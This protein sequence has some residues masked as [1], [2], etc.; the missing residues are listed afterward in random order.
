MIIDRVE[1][2]MSNV[3]KLA[4]EKSYSITILPY[5]DIAYE[6]ILLNGTSTRYDIKVKHVEENF[7]LLYKIFG[8]KKG[9]LTTITHINNQSYFNLED[10]FPEL[11]KDDY[12]EA[13][14][15]SKNIIEE[16]DFRQ[17]NQ[18]FHRVVY[19]SLEEVPNN[20][21]K[22]LSE[23]SD[24]IDEKFAYSIDHYFPGYLRKSKW[25]L[26]YNTAKHGTSYRT[27]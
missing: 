20:T 19:K 8:Y 25:Y 7:D 1:L 10:T 27:L 12:I 24:L 15:N 23:K 3:E 13:R 18:N 6:N 21:L 4:E 16:I 2:G 22:L 26:Y 14:K 17:Q 9:S 11:K 5:F